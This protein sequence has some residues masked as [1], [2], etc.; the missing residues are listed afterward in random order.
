[1][2][3]CKDIFNLKQCTFVN[4]DKIFNRKFSGV[5]I[6]SREIKSKEIFIALEGENSDG[7][8]Y[9]R[10]VFEKKVALAIVNESW[11]I[12]NINNFKEE[13][14][15]VV[16]NTTLALGELAREYK[17]NF[18]I[19]VFCIGGSNGKTSTKDLAGN[20]L[21]QKYNVLKSEGNFNNH[22][23]LPLTLLKLNKNHNFCLLEAGSNH[24]D[25]L[26][27]L[28]DIAE[29][30]FG[31]V[32][33]IG[34][35]HLEFFKNLDGVAKE[36]FSLYEYLLK[37]KDGTCLINLDDAYVRK[38]SNKVKSQNLFS[39]SYNYDSDVKGKFT[40]Y[41][42]NFEPE[43][44]ISYNKKR[45]KTKIATFGKHSIYNGIAAASIGLFFGLSVKQIKDGLSK[46]NSASSK[47]MEV[48]R[49]NIIVVND[50]YNSNP[51]SVSLGLETIKEYKSK[52]QKHIVL[53]DMLE[54]GKSAEK[55]H[56]DIGKLVKKMKFENLYTYGRDSYHIFK[57]AKGIKNNFYFKTKD[58]LSDFLKLVVKKGDI[59]YV[60]GSRGM[61]MEDVVNSLLLN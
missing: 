39:Y 50:A 57:N 1:M 25:E 26:K 28:C 8:N 42:N 2:I 17:K 58:E 30:D 55:V 60:K 52:N 4:F 40:G 45:F 35:E 18:T 9:I 54:M 36:E 19:P 27:Y 56:S 49:K 46:F 3:T 33:N 41:T 53:A 47:R 34:R 44:E 61:Q 37:E 29:P 16:E 51:D 5:S 11:Y 15:A 38:Y 14:F 10:N 24:F 20:V 12:K 59:V 7:H 43:I 13:S 48:S 32:T 31:L 22:I 23:G 21:S 6:D